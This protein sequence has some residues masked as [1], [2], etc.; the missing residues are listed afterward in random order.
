MLFKNSY[1]STGSVEQKNV[2]SL[3]VI[4]AKALIK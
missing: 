2:V 1:G 4:S 3:K